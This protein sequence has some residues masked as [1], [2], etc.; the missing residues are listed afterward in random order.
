MTTRDSLIELERKFWN[1]NA[2]FY[3][4]NLDETCLIAFAQ[5]SG[6]FGKEDIASTIKNGERWHDID[7]SVKGVVEPAPGVAILTYKAHATRA[8]GQPYDAL[9]SSGYVQRDKAWKMAF[10]QQTPLAAAQI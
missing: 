7:I 6:A 1:G 8:N 9:V 5:M 4:Q 2:G 3:R 10:H